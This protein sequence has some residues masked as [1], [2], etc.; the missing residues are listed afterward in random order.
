MYYISVHIYINLEAFKIYFGIKSA[1]TSVEL[2]D[3]VMHASDDIL[4]ILLQT[5]N[6]KVITVELFKLILDA[7]HDILYTPLLK[8]NCIVYCLDLSLLKVLKEILQIVGLC[9]ELLEK[10]LFILLGL[11]LYIES[12]LLKLCSPVLDDLLSR[13]YFFNSTID[14]ARVDLVVFPS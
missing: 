2:V 9:V 1:H 13:L 8:R 3:D 10:L 6:V 5:S 4:V 14:H 7:R 11:L 12:R